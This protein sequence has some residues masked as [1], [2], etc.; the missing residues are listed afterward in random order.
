ML[1]KAEDH[2]RRLFETLAEHPARWGTLLADAAI[3][4]ETVRPA[5]L[6]TG[7]LTD[8]VLKFHQGGDVIL[9]D[10][11][12]DQQLRLLATPGR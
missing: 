7:S 3:E 10:E 8:L 5:P 11:R 4:G 1:P 12:L 6:G 2:L 9:L